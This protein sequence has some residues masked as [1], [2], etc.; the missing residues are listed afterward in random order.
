MSVLT[1]ELILR[2]VST[3]I[4]DE[5]THI[6]LQIILTEDATTAV[7]IAPIHTIMAVLITIALTTAVHVVIRPSHHLRVEEVEEGDNSESLK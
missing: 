6:P 2:Y 4:S 5:M 3:T 7:L 1:S